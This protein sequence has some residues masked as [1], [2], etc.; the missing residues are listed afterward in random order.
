MLL[1][2]VVVP[3]DID[4]NNKPGSG[5]AAGEDNRLI[6]DSTPAIPAILGAFD[7]YEVI[8]LPEAH[9]LKDM[10]DFIFTLIRTENFRKR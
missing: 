5:A 6:T 1:H 2:G 7:K 10:D 3:D 4:S 9:G 8:A